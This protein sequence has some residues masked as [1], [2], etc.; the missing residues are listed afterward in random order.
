M[1]SSRHGCRG[2]AYSNGKADL[3]LAVLEEKIDPRLAVMY[4][5]ARGLRPRLGAAVGEQF[6]AYVRQ[7]RRWLRSDD[8]D[9]GVDDA[10]RWAMKETTLTE[11][12]RVRRIQDKEAPRYDRQ[13]GFYDRIRSL[14]AASGPAHASTAR[15]SS[16]RSESAATCPTTRPTF[17]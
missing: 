13:M 4:E 16:S 6:A 15:S 2:A 14:A 10:L 17:A 8:G 11:T 3:F 5:A 12:E 1:Q 7:Q 9:N